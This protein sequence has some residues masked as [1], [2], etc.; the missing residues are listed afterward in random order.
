VQEPYNRAELRALR[1]TVDERWP[2]L[3]EEE[4][5]RWLSRVKDGRSP[6]IRLRAQA[7]R[8]QPDAIVALALHTG[9]RRAEVL[10]LDVV[11]LHHNNQGVVVRDKDG[12]LDGNCREGPLTDAA[13]K[14]VEAWILCRGFL[15]PNHEQAWLN[16]HAELS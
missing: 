2:K 16:L 5:L 4:A 1:A 10:A 13:R 7:I 15:S 6:Y 3:S 8:C 12:S 11:C 9:L 14:A